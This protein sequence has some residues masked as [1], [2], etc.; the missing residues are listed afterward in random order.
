M[1]ASVMLVT[2]G[3]R[4][5]GAATAHLAAAAGYRVVVNYAANSAAADMVVGDI[6]A[7]GGQAFAIGADV[8]DEEAVL[9]MFEQIDVRYGRLDGLVNN[10]GVVD[11]AERLEDM[12]MDR[13][14]R[15][16]EINVFGTMLCARE[17]V[18]RM[19][20]AHGGRGGTIVNLSSASVTLGS[21]SQFIDYASSKGAVETFTMALAKEVVGE[22]IRVNAV[23]PG[24]I[25]T[26]IHASGGDPDRVARLGSSLPMGRA[27]TAQEVA[28]AIIWLSSDV[29][30]Y[31]TGAVVDVSGGRAV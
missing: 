17:A 15:M 8:S 30:S 21:P 6:I 13:L 14:R 4:G 20:S 19:S 24:I 12:S 31:T 27:G 18:K 5:I 11:D 29:S 3:S 23:R 1:S 16:F 9:A 22:K 10:A 7:D 28:S 26:E 2:G 25:D